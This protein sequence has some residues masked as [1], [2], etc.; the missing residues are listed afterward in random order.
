VGTAQAGQKSQGDEKILQ[1]VHW[2]GVSFRVRRKFRPGRR[3]KVR[4]Q[5]P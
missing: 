1:R 5:S 3:P 4:A 2:W